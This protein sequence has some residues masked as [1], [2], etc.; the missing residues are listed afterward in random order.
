MSGPQ[1]RVEEMTPEE[2]LA[3]LKEFVEE[4]KYVRPGE[5][6]TL[7]GNAFGLNPL[8]PKRKYSGPVDFPDEGFPVTIAP[9]SYDI[10][11]KGPPQKQPGLVRRWLDKR[12]EKKEAK[13]KQPNVIH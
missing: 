4:Q 8:S 7:G 2:R 11:M 1:K 3:S 10:A 6:G 12:K 5:S 13:R 9:P